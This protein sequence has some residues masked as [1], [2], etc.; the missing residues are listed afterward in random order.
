[1]LRASLVQTEG[2]CSVCCLEVVGDL[3][4]CGWDSEQE[5]GQLPWQQLVLLWVEGTPLK[6][7]M[8]LWKKTQK[9]AKG[10]FRVYAVTCRIIIIWGNNI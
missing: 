9:T 3:W 8:H 7:S 10:I 5:L 4:G 6:D 1:M 2:G